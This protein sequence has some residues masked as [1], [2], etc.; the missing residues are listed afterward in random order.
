MTRKHPNARR[1]ALALFASFLFAASA[2]AMLHPDPAQA[3]TT[4]VTTPGKRPLPGAP[5]IP[6]DGGGSTLSSTTSV[7]KQQAW[8]VYWIKDAVHFVFRV[9]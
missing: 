4:T 6:E 9:R 3:E 1:V 7:P 2:C 5:N 8:V